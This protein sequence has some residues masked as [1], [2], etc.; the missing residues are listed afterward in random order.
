MAD[1]R[2]LERSRQERRRPILGAAVRQRRLDGDVA[3][4]VLVLGSEA[5]DRP[6]AEA[7]AG[8]GA[9]TGK[10][11]QQGRAVVDALAHHRMHEAHVVHALAHVGEQIADLDAALAARLEVPQGLHQRPR[12][13]IVEGQRALDRQRLAVVPFQIGL[14]LEGVHRGGAAVHEQEDHALRARLEVGLA[15]RQG[16]GR[17]EFHV[18]RHGKVPLKQAAERQHAETARRVAQHAPAGRRLDR[19]H[20]LDHLLVIHR[21]RRSL[22]SLVLVLGRAQST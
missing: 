3:G 8:E 14:V 2:A 4:E 13:F 7:G 15:D 16:V 22:K 11:L 1:R 18:R 20:V 19:V 5:V 21:S 17:V 12:L 6:R 9:G 10:R